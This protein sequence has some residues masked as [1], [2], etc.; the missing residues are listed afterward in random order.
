MILSKKKLLE[1]VKEE[2]VITLAEANFYRDAKGRLSSCKPGRVRRLRRFR[3]KV[4]SP[5]RSVLV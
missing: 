1:M 4:Y 5:G 2:L 3:L